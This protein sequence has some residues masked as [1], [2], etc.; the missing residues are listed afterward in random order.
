MGKRISFL[1]FCTFLLSACGGSGGDGP[2]DFVITPPPVANTPSITTELVF[3]NLSFTQPVALKQAPGDSTRWFVV[4][5][6]GVVRVFAN[7]Q[8]TLSASVFLDIS[9]RVNAANEGGLLGIAFHPNFN[10]SGQ[11]GEHFLY[12]FYSTEARSD[13][14][15]FTAPLPHLPGHG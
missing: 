6:S 4:E 1:G 9:A 3:P 13:V 8:N 7:D 14:P 15:G 12:V 11:T 10:L 2:P 5:K